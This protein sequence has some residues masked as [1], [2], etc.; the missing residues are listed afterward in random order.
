MTSTPKTLIRS[1][2]KFWLRFP[3]SN[4]EWII[5]L[6]ESAWVIVVVILSRLYLGM[7]FSTDSSPPTCRLGMWVKATTWTGPGSYIA[8]YVCILVLPLPPLNKSAD[9]EG[10]LTFRV[11]V[12]RKLSSS[13]AV[14][15]KSCLAI[16]SIF[17]QLFFVRN[18]RWL[19]LT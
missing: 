1:M 13:S 18:S 14:A 12:L 6:L 17:W 19:R 8:N 5:Q 11:W 16:A 2:N 10:S 4:L 15:E 7:H 9:F 3:T